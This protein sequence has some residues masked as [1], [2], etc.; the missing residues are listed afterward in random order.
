MQKYIIALVIE[1][2]SDENKHIIIH[3]NERNSIENFICEEKY[4]I[5]KLGTKNLIDNSI[6]LQNT[7]RTKREGEIEVLAYIV[8]TTNPNSVLGKEIQKYHE[9]KKINKEVIIED[10]TELLKIHR[11]D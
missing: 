8:P 1:N 10:Q 2:S 7:L 3:T 4:E 9:S 11:N 5:Y 6:E